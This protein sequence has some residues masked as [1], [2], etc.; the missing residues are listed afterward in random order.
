L[1]AIDR[2]GPAVL[3]LAHNDDEVF[4]N[5]RVRALLREGRAVHAVWLTAGLLAPSPEVRRDESRAAMACLGVPAERLT[6]WDYPDL[7]TMAHLEDIV[8]RLVEYFAGRRPSEVY[9]PSYE[10]GHPDHDV[11]NFAVG[12]AVRRLELPARVYEFPINNASRGRVPLIG[13]FV[14]DTVPVL[15]TAPRPEDRRIWRELWP[16]YRT[17][18]RFLKVP[19]ALCLDRSRWVAG[20]PYRPLPRHQY[21]ER[22]HRGRLA[23]EILLGIPFDRFRAAVSDFAEAHGSLA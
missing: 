17:Q 1:V 3:V 21:L 16:C 6:F 23:Y 8:D 18:Y 19:F 13:G 4:I 2:G 11:A 22:P 7:R 12:Q 10:G 20:E 15:R 9:V 14:P 5:A